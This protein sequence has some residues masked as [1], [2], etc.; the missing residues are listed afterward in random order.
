[1]L[2]L[3]ERNKNAV[4]GMDI[5]QARTFL[6]IAATG[7][8]IA[9]AAR[10]HVTQTAVSARVRA[11]EQGLGRQLFVRN[12]SGARLTPAGE[13]FLRSAT[14]LVQIWDHAQRQ[15][16]LPPG[17]R[18][19]ATVAAE[20]SLW[21][22]VLADWLAWMKAQAPDIALR[23]EVDI[24]SR[25]LERVANGSVDMAVLYNP[26][27]QGGDLVVELLA[28]E[29]LVL[30]STRPVSRDGIGNDFVYV[31]WGPAFERSFR[32]A[33]PQLANPTVFVS[34]GPLALIHLVNT[35]G[36]GYFRLGVARPLLEAGKLQL[37][38]DAPAFSHSMYLVYSRQRDAS[39][40]EHMREGFLA[41]AGGPEPVKPP[42]RARP[43][44]PAG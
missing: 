1:M 36:S 26:P 13:R 40:I 32:A 35:G 2:L 9:A 17:R 19:I 37:V 6:E 12:K 14:D 15:V 31:D 41:V 25:L 16:A 34:H 28:E 7:S 43:R 33:Y 22:P 3:D 24:P 10:L 30:V 18:D 8:F 27:T 44:R 11:L 21:N 23:A 39:L 4:S 38:P 20:L 42:E 29:K 5:V